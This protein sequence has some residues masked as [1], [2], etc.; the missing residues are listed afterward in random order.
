MNIRNII[1]TLLFSLLLPITAEAQREP[2][3]FDPK[4]FQAD[5]EQ[6]IVREAVLTPSE[7]EVFFPLYREYIEKKHAL[8]LEARLFTGYKPLTDE[9]CSEAINRSDENDI[10]AKELQLLYHKK[11]LRVLPAGK[12]YDILQAEEKFHRQS[13]RDMS[14]EGR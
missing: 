10:K 14:R 1:I 8:A 13:F 2:R 12:V 7:A 6:F 11:F 5:L 4:Q 3:K 9:Q